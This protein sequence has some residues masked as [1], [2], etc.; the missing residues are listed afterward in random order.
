MYKYFSTLQ[1]FV[2]KYFYLDIRESSV[3]LWKIITH[4]I[5]LS[6]IIKTDCY[7]DCG[8]NEKLREVVRV[9]ES[10]YK[11]TDRSY[12]WKT[13]H[14]CYIS[15]Y[16]QQFEYIETFSGGAAGRYQTHHISQIDLNG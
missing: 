1:T 6:E 8:S 4:M 15:I 10:K 5:K 12:V 7:I 13:T 2:K 9:L 11:F 14:P 16:A 3:T